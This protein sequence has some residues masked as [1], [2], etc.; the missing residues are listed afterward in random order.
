MTTIGQRIRQGGGRAALDSKYTRGLVAADCNFGKDIALNLQAEIILYDCGVAPEDQSA[1][2]VLIM[3]PSAFDQGG[4]NMTM[5]NT[6]IPVNSSASL[7]AIANKR[8]AVAY[9]LAGNLQDN[10]L[11]ATIAELESGRE[12]EDVPGVP[13]AKRVVHGDQGGVAKKTYGILLLAFTYEGGK[14]KIR[15]TYWSPRTEVMFGASKAFGI[16]Q[17]NTITPFT[18]SAMPYNEAGDRV[19]ETIYA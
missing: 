16:S 15:N 17:T 13:G 8:G 3:P 2:P 4:V 11:S 1:A 6:L 18:F 19:I 7:A 9:A 5:D 12:A 10:P 14:R